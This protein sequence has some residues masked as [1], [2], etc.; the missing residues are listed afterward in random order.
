MAT[1]RMEPLGRADLP[2]VTLLLLVVS[3]PA[4]VKAVN[5]GDFI[6]TLT[7][8]HGDS[9]KE[10]PFRQFKNLTIER[11]EVM[12]GFRLNKVLEVNLHQGYIKLSGWHRLYWYDYRFLFDGPKHFRNYM[13][14]P[15]DTTNQARLLDRPW[16]SD[17][18]QGAVAHI[19]VNHE[20]IWVPDVTL[21]QHV[22]GFTENTNS[23]KVHVFDESFVKSLEARNLPKFNMFWSRS[24]VLHMKCP[25]HL[26]DFPFD[27]NHCPMQWEAWAE[28]AYRLSPA[29]DVSASYT[30][31]K[32]YNVTLTYVKS[33][34][35]PYPLPGGGNF[36]LF[37][38]AL[39]DLKLE[40]YAHYYVINYILPIATMVILAWLTFFIPMKAESHDRIAYTVT[41]MLT[42]MAVNFITAENRPR[43]KEDMWLDHFQTWAF[44]A[45]FIPIVQTAT[46][47]RIGRIYESDVA[48][49]DEIANKDIGEVVNYI[50]RIF[51]VSYPVFLS[52]IA[53]Y[54]FNPWSPAQ[55]KQSDWTGS[56]SAIYFTFIGSTFIA[57]LVYAVFNFT[58]HGRKK[59]AGWT[60]ELQQLV[61]EHKTK[62]YSE[63]DHSDEDLDSEHGGAFPGAPDG[64]VEYLSRSNGVW[65]PAK[66]VGVNADG[67]YQLDIIAHAAGNRIRPRTSDVPIV[68]VPKSSQ[69]YEG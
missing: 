18:T 31:T 62:A 45:V 4:D 55:R 61:H 2:I 33:G 52:V 48:A 9:L 14:D 64:L 16:N 36:G 26:E 49:E 54:L 59:F 56:T 35:R 66:V 58:E 12:T 20:D 50:D 23:Y 68:D 37:D 17:I 67:T 27:T 3:F 11:P 53:A 21:H 15:L 28:N 57:L 65:Y 34:N 32:E 1:S 30:T 5:P 46:L 51:R 22:D 6:R 38:Y 40:R 10:M 39:F 60:I 63:A 69:M 42:V 29:L 8:T 13:P 19:Q 47:L 25:I 7:N 43:T 24:T 41:L 44:V